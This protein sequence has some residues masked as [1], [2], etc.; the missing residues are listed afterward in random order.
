MGTTTVRISEQTRATLRE[1]AEKLGEP[2]HAVLER[3]VEAYRRERFFADVDAAYARLRAD[4][5]AWR[6]ELEERSELDGVLA[7]DLGEA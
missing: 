3:A 5:D 2:M 1:L 6:E 4:P 7:D